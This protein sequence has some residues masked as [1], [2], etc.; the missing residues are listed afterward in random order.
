[1][2]NICFGADINYNERYKLTPTL[3]RIVMIKL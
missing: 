1:M 2:Q 3:K